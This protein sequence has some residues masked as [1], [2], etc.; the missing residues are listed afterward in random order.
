MTKAA[1]SERALGYIRV[2]TQGQADNG[3]SLDHQE[4]SLGGHYRRLGTDL[5]GIYL[6]RGLSG[7][8]NNRPGLQA[9]FAHELRPGSRI[10]KIGVCSICRL[11]R[12]PE[13]LDHYRQRLKRA[14]VRIFTITEDVGHDVDRDHVRITGRRL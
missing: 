4:S 7:T 6:G 9:L 3:I 2:S 12:D 1:Q 13:T 5:V 8:S 11:F 10:S 14:G